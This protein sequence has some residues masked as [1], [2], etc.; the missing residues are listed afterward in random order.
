MITVHQV[1]NL[2]ADNANG[3]VTP[4]NDRR[5]YNM[6]VGGESGV[7]QGCEVTAIGSTQLRVADGWGIV[8]GCLFTIEAETIDATLSASGTVNGRLLLQVDVSQSAGTFITQAEASLPALQQDD[9]TASGSIYQLELAT[10]TASSIAIEN[11]EQTFA[12]VGGSGFSSYAVQKNGT[13]FALSGVGNNVKFIAPAAF[14]DGNTFTV[15]GAAVTA[16]TQ[17][18]EALSGGYFVSGAVVTAYLNRSTLYF[19]SGGAAL[20]FKVVG[21]TTQPANPSENTI[22]VNTDTAIASWAFSADQ[23][24][25]AEGMVWISTGA[26]STASFNALK[27]NVLYVYPIVCLQYVGGAW[28]NKTALLYQRGEWVSLAKYLLQGADLHAEN[29][30]TWSSDG[31]GITSGSGWEW[32]NYSITSNGIVIDNPSSTY[33]VKYSV[34]G[35]QEATSFVGYNTLNFVYDITAQTTDNLYFAATESI[36]NINTGTTAARKVLNSGQTIGSYTQTIDVSS[37]N[38]NYYVAFG[39]LRQGGILLREVYLA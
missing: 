7:V 17:D 33:N 16:L 26:Q 11:V 32:N 4:I 31:W 8:S 15:N 27:K 37:L 18:G 24:T 34:C 25:G 29:G 6:L 35:K 39:L 38:G 5:F 22:W 21:G 28:N 12:T 13:V 10:Y 3:I 9:L 36:T 14:E 20:N 2:S 30:G 23:P 1:N 19:N